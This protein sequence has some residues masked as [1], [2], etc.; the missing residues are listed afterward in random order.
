MLDNDLL[1]VQ[2][3]LV[4]RA[5]DADDLA[6]LQ[7]IV[8]NDT[9][10]LTPYRQAVLWFR[11]EGVKALSGVLEPERNA[12]Y[13]QWLETL[14]SVLPENEPATLDASSAPG[15]AAGDWD[16][17]LPAHAAWL[18]L[19]SSPGSGLV[20]AGGLLLARDEAWTSEDLGALREWVATWRVMHHGKALPERRLGWRARAARLRAR[21]GKRGVAWMAGVALVLAVP[22][23]LTVLAPGELVPAD[24]I[25]IRA[26][27]D[28][29]VSKFHVRPNQLVTK[30]QPLFSFDD[31]A[32]GSRFEVAQQAL[33]TAEAELRQVE[34][35][36]MS[37]PKA[38]MQLPASRGNVT[39][40]RA[41]LELLRAQRGRLDVLAPQD[42]Y[43]LFDDP[44]E[45]TG[46]PV[47]T[48]ERIMRL[49]SADDREIEA[50]LGIGDAIPLPANADA[51][52]YLS[53]SPLDPVTG[54]VHFV[55]HDVTRRPDGQYAYR[56]RARLEQGTSHRVGLKG[57]V[58][59]S[60]ERVALGYWIIRRPLA[61]IRELL[62]I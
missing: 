5:R 8:V 52:L 23:P 22:V 51:R 25:M 38:R 55:S 16:E 31:I 34:Q 9:H 62:G 61:T 35:Q 33:L 4:R 50:W 48:G 47:S 10:L 15:P 53:A 56:V 59:L 19:P 20:P 3:E 32:L 11:G 1:A 44:S 14:C 7:F 39:E 21:I 28:G 58:R 30:G 41:E 45:W 17:W 46:R 13:V 37:D 27:L 24:P 60:G 2:M 43:I 57:T 42:G 26:P 12:P 36:S 6:A 18:P 54:Y 49:A 40:R 29:V